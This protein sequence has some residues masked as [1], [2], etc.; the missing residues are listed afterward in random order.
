MAYTTAKGTLVKI[1]SGTSPE[2]FS[3]IG[4]VRGISGP[5]VSANIVETTSHSTSG[6]WAEKLAVL[7]DPGTVSFTI[8]F[9]KADATH[10]FTTG[11]W[12][13]FQGLTRRNFQTVLA[14]NMGTLKYAAYVSSHQFNAPVNDVLTVDIELTLTGAITAQTT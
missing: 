14:G 13:I 10:A 3:T 12:N 5:T 4:Y 8:N 2:T 7:L 11:L 1:G 9:D 6:N